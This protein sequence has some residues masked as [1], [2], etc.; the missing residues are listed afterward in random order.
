MILAV[1]LIVV[2]IVVLTKNGE[3]KKEN[4]RLKNNINNNNNQN[5]KRLNFCPL[6]GG[7]LSYLYSNE[8]HVCTNTV[9][10]TGVVNNT[11]I[12][13]NIN[14]NTV[15][16]VVVKKKNYTDKEVKNTLILI[17]GSVLLVLS[18]L[19]FL[20]TTWNVT[21][22]IFKTLILLV[23]LA[24]FIITSYIADKYLHL[25]QTSKAF[26]YISL[27]YIP[28]V[29]LSISVF[30]LI[31]SFFSITGPGKYIYLALSS[32]VVTLIYYYNS[33]KKSEKLVGIFSMIFSIITICLIGACFTTKFSYLLLFVVAY[34][35]VLN[36]I[37]K[38]KLYYI[39]DKLHLNTIK[40]LSYSLLVL[41][42]YNSLYNIIINNVLYSDFIINILLLGNLY[43]LLT[44]IS[45]NKNILKAIYPIYIIFIFFNITFLCNEFVTKQLLILLSFG[46]SYMINYLDEKYINNYCFFEVLS[47]FL[48]LLLITIIYNLTNITLI[49][50]YI[51]VLIMTV[52]SFIHYILYKNDSRYPAVIFSILLISF[53]LSLVAHNEWPLVYLGF[54]SLI[55]IVSGMTFIGD[56][57]LKGAFKII[58]NTTF[59]INTFCLTNVKTLTLLLFFSYICVVFLLFIQTKFKLYKVISYIYFNVLLL[60]FV[61]YIGFESINIFIRVLPITT[62]LLIALEYLISYLRDDTNRIYII[63][64][65]IFSYLLLAFPEYSFENLLLVVILSTAF[66]IFI[67]YNK[68][69]NNLSIISFIFL[70]PHIYFSKFAVIND[71]NLMFIISI[72]MLII[73]AYL[74]YDKKKNKY[75]I[76]YFVYTFFHITVF[77]E[78]HYLSLLIFA[79][80]T[81]INYYINDEGKIKDLFLG[82]MFTNLLVLSQFLISDLEWNNI[83]VIRYLPYLIWIPSITRGILKKYNVNYKVWEYIGYILLNLIAFAS[84][85]NELDGILF[86]SSLAVLV[87]ISY[88]HKYGPIFIVCLA[89]ILINTLLLTRNFWLGLPWWLYILLIGSVLVGFAIH[90]ELNEKK[91]SSLIS[92]LRDKIDL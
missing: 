90:N 51:I 17:T 73:F 66:I 1:I 7:N 27:A 25:Q 50:P 33:Y 71:F 32:F 56:D 15:N 83:T 37:Y 52:L 84:Y 40:I 43:Y 22:A 41:G 38:L 39:N 9:N 28:I 48:I 23:M 55:M 18:A 16:K 45:P 63:I 31:G 10:N 35:S 6:C 85:T 60:A 80:G 61:K 91:E 24:I 89:S 19:L 13:T 75:M 69:D 76:L 46:I 64:Q 54:A 72:I 12:N 3:L 36:I 65:T 4:D 70:I 67:K 44:Y 29:L 8:N 30:E 86:V 58:G 77:K 14:T 78:S 79:I 49:P 88:N 53:V 92:K 21:N 47:S 82:I 11:N 2:L 20:T 26:H 87:I 81:F 5:N 42:I 74:N 57:K 34:L 59:I 62:I 68:M